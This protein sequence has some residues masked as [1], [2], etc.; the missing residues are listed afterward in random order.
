MY[1]VIRAGGKQYRVAPGDV[2]RL[3]NQGDGTDGKIEFNDV[4]AV[5]A[6][7]GQIGR[8]QSSALVTGEVVEQGRAAKI[9]VFHYKRKKQYKKLRGHRQGYTAVRITEIAFDGQK[10]AAPDVLKKE[11]KPKKAKPEAEEPPKAESKSKSKPSAKKSAA[12]KPAP[13]KA[14]PKKK[15]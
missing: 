14:A 4:L 5:S 11:P 7:A 10:F 1:A 12:K 15:K 13:K 3:E 2:I 9:P 8:P 6:E